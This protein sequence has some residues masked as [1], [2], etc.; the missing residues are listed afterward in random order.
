M[1]E[2][3][4]VEVA[5]SSELTHVPPKNSFRLCKGLML[6]AL[7]FSRKRK[8][9]HCIAEKKRS[10]RCKAADGGKADWTN[11][12][13][14]CPEGVRAR[15]GAPESIL[16]MN[17]RGWLRTPTST[18]TAIRRRYRGGLAGVVTPTVFTVGSPQGGTPR[19]RGAG[20]LICMAQFANMS[21]DG[22]HTYMGAL[23]RN[24]AH[25]PLAPR[26]CGVLPCIKPT[27]KTVGA[28]PRAYQ[29]TER[30]R[31]A[32]WISANACQPSTFVTSNHCIPTTPFTKTIGT[33]V[34]ELTHVPL[35]FHSRY[36]RC[37]FI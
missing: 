33:H 15:W 12:Q 32:V 35:W 3:G 29:S 28:S 6:I 17:G 1:H 19:S 9:P 21:G 37:W 8:P 24:N 27:V 11:R 25:F 18:H 20:N 22:L 7:K 30:R 13:A 10:E 34:S 16:G 4:K 23:L 26:V 2:C 5:F 31:M 14:V 36:A